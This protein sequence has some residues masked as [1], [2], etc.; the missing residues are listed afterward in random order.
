MR[1]KPHRLPVQPNPPSTYEFHV[2]GPIGPLVRA[3]LPECTADAVP[4]STTLTGT[5]PNL[6]E[7]QRLLGALAEHGADITA[8][9]VTT[10]RA[11]STA[12]ANS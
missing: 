6:E 3:A 7:L 10:H 11:P 2:A 4:T 1:R 9:K 8:L 12:A 5:V